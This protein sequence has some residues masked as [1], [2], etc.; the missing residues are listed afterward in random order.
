M[1]VAANANVDSVVPFDVVVINDKS[2]EKK[3]AP[4]DA[5]TWFSARGRCNYR[6]GPKAKVQFHSWELVPGQ[7]FRLDVPVSAD[8]KAVFGFA[9]YTTPGD[10]RV[11]LAVAGSQ[12]VDMDANGVHV[13]STV[14]VSSKGAPPAPEMQKVCPDD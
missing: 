13:Q 6:G 1:N 10:H 9:D 4:M 8:T 14:P 11:P 3:I 2:L 5:S 7:S 12:F